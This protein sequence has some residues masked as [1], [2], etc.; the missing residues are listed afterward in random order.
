MKRFLLLSSLFLFFLISLP[1]NVLFAQDEVDCKPYSRYRPDYQIFV[2]TSPRYK[3]SL[4][5]ARK[6]SK[7]VT[8]IDF[9]IEDGKP[10]DQIDSAIDNLIEEGRSHPPIHY[11]ILKFYRILLSGLI[12]N[13]RLEN[14]ER[15]ANYIEY[16]MQEEGLY[17][18][19]VTK[20][21]PSLRG[22]WSD[23]RIDSVASASYETISKMLTQYEEGSYPP[24]LREKYANSGEYERDWTCVAMLYRPF[25]DDLVALKED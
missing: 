17:L 15:I 10:Y 12:S 1:V 23:S 13:N 7:L 2:A 20:A 8:D 3:M 6:F 19:A 21:L 4:L 16:I 9:M 14:Q 18:D 5:Q 25:L 11:S 24:A 22:Y